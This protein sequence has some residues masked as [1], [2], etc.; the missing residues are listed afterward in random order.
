MVNNKCVIAASLLLIFSV[1]ACTEK[2]SVE[3]A[4]NQ[5][6]ATSP[7]AEVNGWIY[8]QMKEWYLWTDKLGEKSKTNNT[9][10]PDAYFES[11][12]Y[13]YKTTDRFSW[14][15]ES[16]EALINSLSG[17]NTVLGIRSSPFFTNASK[18]NVAFSVA[19]VL[20]DSPAEKAGLKRGD[21]IT[22]VNGV[23]ITNENYGTAFSAESLSM[24]LGDYVNGE[25]IPNN[26]VLTATKAEVQTDPV[27][28]STVVNSGNKK[29]GYLTYIQFIPGIRKSDGSLGTEF[30][31]ELRSV[32]ADFK[33]KGVNELVL[34]LRYNGGGYISSAV[35]LASLIGKNVN[36]S[37]IAYTDEWNAAK[38]KQ[39]GGPDAFKKYFRNEPN[40]IGGSINRLFVLTSNGTASASELVINM[41]RPYM[42]VV[43]VGEHT[44][45]K[46]VG[47]I[48]ISDDK[49]RWNWG[50]QPIVLKTYNAR[51]ESDYGSET[52]FLPNVEL[53][54]NT[55]PF[56]NFG[57]PTENLFKGVISYITGVTASVPSPNARIKAEATFDQVSPFS[58]SDN[59]RQNLYDMFG[60]LPKQ[61]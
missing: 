45:G 27:Q 34:D 6:V 55:L 9:L 51:G 13:Q 59:P 43:L 52:G 42:D 35:V 56:K 61:K 44:Y 40:N 8:D 28:F 15:Q 17:K 22:K 26:K 50:M 18:T 7:N 21:F 1:S 53:K 47:S 36:T 11:I 31:D 14:I 37:K 3:P 58:F 38:I 41:L 60:E 2:T 29:I 19:Y 4:Q 5:A 20:K 10:A 57:D 30:D 25:I 12:L 24:T 32:F 49:K 23:A 16:S 54:D 39:Y 33:A 46:N 48:T